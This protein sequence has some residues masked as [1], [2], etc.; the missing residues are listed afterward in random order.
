M[1]APRGFPSSLAM[2]FAG[3][4]MTVRSSRDEP[5]SIN[6]LLMS[7]RP[8][9][10]TSGSNLSSDGRFMATT[11]PGARITGEPTGRSEITTVQ[12]A[13]PPRISGPYDGSHETSL[14][15]FIPA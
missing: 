2:S 15:S 3:T 14:P 11:A 9:G 8:P 10:L 13:V 4:S 6:E 12:F 1:L 5:R 7:S